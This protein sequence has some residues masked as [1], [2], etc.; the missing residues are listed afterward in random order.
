M[1]RFSSRTQTKWSA[2]C[3]ATLCA[4]A[5]MSSPCTRADELLDAL[6]QGVPSS[7]GV[8]V[9][10]DS[11]DVISGRVSLDVGLPSD[12]RVQAGFENSRDTSQATTLTTNAYWIG[13]TN[14][15]L[16]AVNLGVRYERT[17]SSD[18]VYSDAGAASLV[19]S[20]G[21]WDMG[22]YPS[23][24]IISVQRPVRRDYVRIR[25][26]GMGFQLGYDWGAFSLAGR[27]D[28]LRYY[29]GVESLTGLTLAERRAL[30]RDGQLYAENRNSV[31]ASMR[32]T[33][34]TLTAEGSR[35]VSVIDGG[36]ERGL[37]LDASLHVNSLVDLHGVAGATRDSVSGTV[38]FAGVGI[39]LFW[40]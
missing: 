13:V 39:V 16:A 20:P 35:S 17:N 2:G 25:N 1:T 21:H 10:A 37:T 19:W 27:H 12:D 3:A 36:V 28:T 31:T 38:R 30:A 33:R 15:P 40:E 8:D 11:S 5:T 9:S 26:P 14:D 32:W 23:Y 24:R 22:W 29:S 18:N 7:V 34:L 4:V 6:L